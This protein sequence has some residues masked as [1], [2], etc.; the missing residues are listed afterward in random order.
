MFCSNC[1]T[2]LPDDA[3]VCPSCGTPVT[4]E[5]EI[6]MKEIA[7]YAGNKAKDAFDTIVS[8][9]AEYS[10]ELKQKGQEMQESMERQKEQQGRK[11]CRHIPPLPD[12][13]RLINIESLTLSY[14]FKT[15]FT[16]IYKMIPFQ[17]PPEQEKRLCAPRVKP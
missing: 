12:K 16:D 1:G 9:T 14:F 2:Q 17:C 7:N 6:N 15:L 13:I 5:N 8:K 11:N 4:S 3:K 10:S